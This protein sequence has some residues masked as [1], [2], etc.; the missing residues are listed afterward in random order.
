M[1]SFHW[2][3]NNLYRDIKTKNSNSPNPQS[4]FTFSF[5]LDLNLHHYFGLSYDK[6]YK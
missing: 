4:I 6:D 5:A 1:P 2:L 3:C